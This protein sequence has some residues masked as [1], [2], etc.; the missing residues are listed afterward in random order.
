M[1]DIYKRTNIILLVHFYTNMI[2]EKITSHKLLGIFYVGSY[3]IIYSYTII[4]NTIKL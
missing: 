4:T 1:T 3:Y 2:T